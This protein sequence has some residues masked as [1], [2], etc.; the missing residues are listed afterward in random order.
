MIRKV[1]AIH[2]GIPASDGAGV[3]LTRLLHTPELEHLDPFLLLDQF[4]SDDPNAYIAG[5]PSHPHRGFET[6]TYLLHGE[7]EHQDSHGGHGILRAG[8][9]QYMTAGRG[10]IHSEMPRQ[11]DGLLWG[12]QL[13]INLPAASKMQPAAYWDIPASQIPQVDFPGGHARVI[14]GELLGVRGPAPERSTRVQYWDVALSDQAVLPLPGDLAAMIAVYA[15]QVEV[16]GQRLTAPQ[17]T[18]PHLATLTTGDELALAGDGRLL[19]IAGLPIG[20]PVARQ[21]PF[22]MNTRQQIL[23]AF[24]D[25]RAGRF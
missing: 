14:A 21:G 20:E 11:Q 19:V 25:Y 3:R 17:L 18:A 12:F 24:S 13:W 1:S 15:G 6:L 23:E 22:V 16:S 2:A 10:I 7:M 5:F 4:K 8:G 9:V